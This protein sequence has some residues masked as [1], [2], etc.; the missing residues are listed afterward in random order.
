MTEEKDTEVSPEP[1]SETGKGPMLDLSKLMET[2]E[3]GSKSP[4]VTSLEN[5]L[6]RAKSG[7]LQSV[8]VI[9]GSGDGS[10][11]Y[12]WRG[13]CNALQILG[14]LAVMKDGVLKSLPPL[15]SELP[16]TSA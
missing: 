13:D 2:K 16:R 15:S 4:I 3:A 6:E 10:I 9:T 11:Q 1:F 14:Q 5:A 7:A 12:V 8:I